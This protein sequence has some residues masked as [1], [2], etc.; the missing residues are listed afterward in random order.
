MTAHE[1]T[2]AGKPIEMLG[3]AGKHVP[4]R[5]LVLLAAAAVR[6][7][8]EHL[9][10]P[11]ARDALA[12]IELFHDHL[13]SERRYAE[14]REAAWAVGEEWTARMVADGDGW[15]PHGLGYAAASA[16]A[17]A[18]H[19]VPN[20]GVSRAFWFV[21]EGCIQTA[22]KGMKTEA[23]TAIRSRLCDAIREIVGNPFR[24]FK[25]APPWIGRGTIQPDGR[26]VPFTATVADLAAVIHEGGHYDRLPI[27][28]DAL[29]DAGIDDADLL[30]HG[31]NALSHR[32]GCWALDVA[33]L[34]G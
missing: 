7:L 29:E 12:T 6:L 15:E 17:A 20:A 18:V 27:L 30:A 34:R 1:W 13:A 16:L 4:P 21:Q 2:S 9:T 33:L 3:I 24:R 23:M 32:R 26:F 11:R 19:P 10:D 22:A 14:A 28:A 25:A 31:R 5:K 8:D